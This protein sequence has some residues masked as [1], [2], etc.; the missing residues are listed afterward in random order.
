VSAARDD[1][2]GY[3]RYR[4]AFVADDGESGIGGD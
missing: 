1:F 3:R 2:V 4:Y